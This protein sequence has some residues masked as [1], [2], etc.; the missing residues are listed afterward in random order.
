MNSMF[1]DVNSNGV[2]Q[3]LRDSFSDHEDIIFYQSE[4]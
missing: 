3:H 1:L 2:I 4:I